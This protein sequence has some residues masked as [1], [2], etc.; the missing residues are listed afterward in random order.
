MPAKISIPTGSRF[1]RLTVLQ[2]DPQST[3]GRIRWICQCDCGSI[4][5]VASSPL[6]TGR[7]QSCGCLMREATSIAHRT[8]GLTEKVPEYQVWLGMRGR[9]LNANDSK[10][11]RYGGRGITICPEWGNF[12]RFYADM[13]PR[14]SSEYSIG[15]IDNDGPYAPWNCQ[16]ETRLEQAGNKSNNTRI[17]HD[18]QTKTLAEWSRATGIH[19]SLIIWRLRHGW[20]AERALTQ[21]IRPITQRSRTPPGCAEPSRSSLPAS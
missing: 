16:W 8:H 10:Y 18:G 12:A 9:C 2:E 19:G 17:T 14:P 4:R 21:K 6:R 11:P 20:S 15:R 3:Y 5:S 7:T 1:G 13:G